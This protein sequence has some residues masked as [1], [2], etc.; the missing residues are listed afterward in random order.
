MIVGA[1]GTEVTVSVKV[2]LAEFTPSLAVTVILLVP[3]PSA[4]GVAVTVRF[5]PEPPKTIL[6]TG[7][8]VGLLDVTLRVSEASGASASP[9]MNASAPVFPSSAMVR[10]EIAVMV[11]AVRSGAMSM[12]TRLA[13]EVTEPSLTLKVKVSVPSAPGLGV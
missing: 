12:V 7:T 6:A 2:R 9:M 4:T 13:S 8:S 3:N 5:A 1:S 10:E 11:G